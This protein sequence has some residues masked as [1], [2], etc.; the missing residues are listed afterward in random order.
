MSRNQEAAK[1][2][3]DMGDARIYT[4]PPR[5]SSPDLEG[6]PVSPEELREITSN[7]HASLLTTRLHTGGSGDP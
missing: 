6:T 3:N 7:G 1:T 4:F 2:G 5:S